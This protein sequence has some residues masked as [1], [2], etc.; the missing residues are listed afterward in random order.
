MALDMNQL[1][2][3]FDR[4][5]NSR[6]TTDVIWKP[7]QLQTNIRIV[8]YKFNLENP[9]IE[10]YFHYNVLGRTYLSP[11]SFSRPDPFVEFAENLRATGETDKWKASKRLMPKLRT[12]APIIVRG[13]ETE[14]IR[15]WGFGKT[16]YQ[17]LLGYMLDE[18]YG[19]LSDPVN[20]RDLTVWATQEE[21]KQFPT[22]HIRPKA[23]ACKLHTN[24]DVVK[25]I[26]NSQRD[27]KEIYE[28]KPYEELKVV[29]EK[30]L[31]P[32]D[33][34]DSDNTESSTS[35]PETAQTDTIENTEEAVEKINK[36]FEEVFNQK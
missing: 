34:N 13:K 19:D 20:G 3:S 15:F 14:G 16:V 30:F 26:A 4:L 22:T 7:T 28:E 36:T 33:D 11:I 24:S 1:K 31:N 23:N 6:K 9:F 27:L 29:L 5:K 12:F 25:H 21:G 32:E 35:T 17:E 8:P 2:R 10:L 18:G